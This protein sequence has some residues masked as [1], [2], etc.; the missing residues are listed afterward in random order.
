MF[1]KP[2]TSSS[3]KKINLSVFN[4]TF[5]DNILKIQ[6]INSSEPLKTIEKVPYFSV[7]S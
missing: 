7:F 1:P 6:N 3:H 4:Y 2:F 5:V